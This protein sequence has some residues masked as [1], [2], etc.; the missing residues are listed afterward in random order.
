MLTE[1]LSLATSAFSGGLLGVVGAALTKLFDYKNKKLDIESLKLKLDNDLRCKEVDERIMRAEWDGRDRISFTEAQTKMDVAETEA[2]KASILSDQR[3]YSTPAK[4]SRAMGSFLAFT[5]GVRG[6]IRPTIT[7]GYC[8]LQAALLA[9][10]II[11]ISKKDVTPDQAFEA[12]QQV[13]TNIMFM[14]NIA[15][16]Y[17]FGYHTKE[18]KKIT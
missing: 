1:V 10:I 17:W 2:F 14:T 9:Q 4:M 8:T 13:V 18:Q 15:V 11:F 16:G 5:D 12:Y 7:L 6:L 3:A